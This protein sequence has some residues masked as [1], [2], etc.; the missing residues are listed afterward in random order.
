MTEDIRETVGVRNPY[1]LAAARLGESV[2]WDSLD[3]NEKRK[4]LAEALGMDYHL[5]FD[6]VNEGPLYS[7]MRVI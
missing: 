6:P 1:A 4:K 2:D 3:S 7:N 5:L